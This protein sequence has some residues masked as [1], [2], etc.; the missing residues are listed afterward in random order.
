VL[1]L[2]GGPGWESRSQQLGRELHG[3]ILPSAVPWG[4]V[5]VGEWMV[6]KPEFTMYA[7]ALRVMV[8]ADS[9]SCPSR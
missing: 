7:M 5:R 8:G 6:P 3:N 1:S 9:F 2:E 4:S